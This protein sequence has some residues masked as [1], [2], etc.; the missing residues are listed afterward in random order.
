MLLGNSSIF[1]KT[2]KKP[3]ASTSFV[4]AE[5]RFMAAITC[6][7]KWLKGLLLSLG[8]H[9]PKAIKLFWDSQFALHITKNSI[10]HEEPKTLK[11]IVIFFE[12]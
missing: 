3:S 4:E 7:P 5:Y 1:W 2:K 6:E 10:F 8:V 11:L 9:H 12:M